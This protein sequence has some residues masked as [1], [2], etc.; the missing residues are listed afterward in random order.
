MMKIRLKMRCLAPGWRCKLPCGRKP[1]GQR[2][3][4]GWIAPH[5]RQVQA[6]SAQSKPVK[7]LLRRKSCSR[8]IRTRRAALA[9]SG[10]RSFEKIV[11]RQRDDDAIPARRAGA[12]NVAGTII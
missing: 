12:V 5:F 6:S 9:Q 2:E 1:D 10:N 11:L 3:S 8:M 4:R 7:R